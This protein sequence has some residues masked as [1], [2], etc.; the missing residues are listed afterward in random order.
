[1]TSILVPYSKIF[2]MRENSENSEIFKTKNA[3]TFKNKITGLTSLS[4]PKLVTSKFF[5]S[6]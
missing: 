5:K 1:M 4:V 3:E 2:K 6:F